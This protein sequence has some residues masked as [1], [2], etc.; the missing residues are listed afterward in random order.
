MKNRDL[1]YEK[2]IKSY[3]ERKKLDL[4]C[5]SDS[6]EWGIYITWLKIWVCES[7]GDL[8]SVMVM[9]VVVMVVVREIINLNY[10]YLW[11]L[12]RKLYIDEKKENKTEGN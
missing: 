3:M 2:L 12:W 7:N 1:W 9:V 5:I 11:K 10:C 8:I 4:Y 6:E